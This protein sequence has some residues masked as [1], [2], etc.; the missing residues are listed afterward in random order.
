MLFLVY[1]AVKSV[2]MFFPMNF[3]EVDHVTSYG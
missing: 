1:L 2:V 3:V